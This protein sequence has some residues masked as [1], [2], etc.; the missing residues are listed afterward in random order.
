MPFPFD[1]PFDFDAQITSSASAIGVCT[2][3]AVAGKISTA[4]ASASGVCTASASGSNLLWMEQQKPTYKGLVKVVLTK[5]GQT[6]LTYTNEDLLVGIPSHIESDNDYVAQIDLNNYNNSFTD[7]DLLGYQ[8]VISWG[9]RTDAGDLYSPSAPLTV[10]FQ[11]LTSIGGS[12]TCSLRC[13][14]SINLINEQ[15]ASENYLPAEGNTDTLKGIANGILAGVSYGFAI[16]EAYTTSWDS[17]D[18]LID[19]FVLKNYFS[20]RTGSSRLVKLN[21]VL[22][23]S[24]EVKRLQSDGKI[25]FLNPT[26]S[27]TTYHYEYALGGIHTFYNKSYARTVKIPNYIVIANE[28][29]SFAGS[30]KD[31]TGWAIRPNYRGLER[32]ITSNAQGNLVAAA[33][34][35]RATLSSQSLYS[36]VRMNVFQRV[37]DYVKITDSREGGS[38]RTGNVQFIERTWNSQKGELGMIIRM[39]GV[40]SLDEGNA[41]ALAIDSLIG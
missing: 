12:L 16:F 25:H 8:A 15:A 4:S 41:L 6:T 31:A 11:Q 30:A 33:I 28:D 5:A 23:Y 14:S 7:L 32:P 40:G 26:I 37:W 21:E 13:I 29:N 20:V 2:T 19:S 36:K 10:I 17:E 35:Q 27:G 1:F 18:D 24:K 39:G 34:L 38:V 22:M 3:T 9:A